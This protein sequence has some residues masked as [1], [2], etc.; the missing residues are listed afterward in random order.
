M[1]FSNFSVLSSF[2]WKFSF[3]GLLKH[4]KNRVSADFCVFCC[5]QRRKEPQKMI[6]GISGFVFLSKNGRFVTHNCFSKMWCAETPIFIVFWG[7]AL[8]GPSCQ[9]REF[10][11]TPPKKKILTDNWKAHF[12]VFW[13]CLLLFLFFVVFCFFL[14]WP[15]RP[16]LVNPFLL[17]FWGF[18]GQVRWPKGPPHLA[19]NPPYFC[20]FLVFL[21]LLSFLCF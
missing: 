6:T 20:F 18:K 17:F 15:E 13:V 9:K 3:L 10:L 19:L 11:D 21:F 14:Y 1:G 8:S 16:P 7:C 4:Y 12:L 5:W 2:F